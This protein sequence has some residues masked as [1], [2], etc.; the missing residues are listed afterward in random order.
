MSQAFMGCTFCQALT[1]ILDCSITTRLALPELRV[2]R[3]GSLGSYYVGFTEP[4]M[5]AALVCIE[6]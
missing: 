4:V 3:L 5:E 1:L 2:E 6:E